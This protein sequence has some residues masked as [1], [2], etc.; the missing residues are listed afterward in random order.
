MFKSVL[1]QEGW[2][3]RALVNWGRALTERAAIAQLPEASEK[4]YTAAIDKFE[5]VLEEEPG[6]VLAQYRWGR[7]VRSV[8]RWLR[9]CACC[10]DSCLQGRVLGLSHV[11]VP[12][13]EAATTGS[14]VGS[15]GWVLSFRRRV[16]TMLSLSLSAQCL[17][18]PLPSPGVR[19][20]CRA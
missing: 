12:A 15:K 2:S 1:E 18:A 3:S 10:R 8:Q 5:A 11:S 19:S 17:T 16:L 20:P 7:G 9:L 13:F 14:C 4:L 6:T